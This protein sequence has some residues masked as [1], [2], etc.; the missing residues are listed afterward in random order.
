MYREQVN[1]LQLEMFQRDCQKVT[2]SDSK[3]RYVSL[4]GMKEKAGPRIKEL[5]IRGENPGVR[6][7][8]NQTEITRIGNPPLQ[9]VYNE[10]RTEEITDAADGV[11]YH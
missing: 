10:L 3:Y 11:F 4:D 8:F 1:E 6:F 9:G 2:I 5:D 7:L